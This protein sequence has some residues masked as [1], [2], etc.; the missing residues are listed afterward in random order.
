M[1]D[2]GAVGTGDAIVYLVDS[3]GTETKATVSAIDSDD[4]YITLSSA[5]ASG[6]TIYITYEWCYDDPATPSKKIALACAFLTAAYCYEKINRGMS[7]QQVYGN[8]RFMRDMRAGNEYF[9]RYENQIS[10]INGEMGSWAE[11]EVF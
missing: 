1:D 2:D 5:P 11:A 8:V 10:K 6:T 9:Q 7:P 3:S 4:C